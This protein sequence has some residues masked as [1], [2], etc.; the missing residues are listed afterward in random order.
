MKI[1]IPTEICPTFNDPEIF[2]SP[3]DLD[4]RFTDV[5][6]HEYTNFSVFGWTDHTAQRVVDQG[7]MVQGPYASMSAKASMITAHKQAPR[8]KIFISK[9]DTLEIDGVE[10]SIKWDRYGYATLTKV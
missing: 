5:P 9:D 1:V 7:P 4:I 8:P 6:R 10:Y 2:S 3:R